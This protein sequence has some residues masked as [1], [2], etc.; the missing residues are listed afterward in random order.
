MVITNTT[1]L[2]TCRRPQCLESGRRDDIV[3]SGVEPD[4]PARP[5]TCHGLRYDRRVTDMIMTRR[6]ALAL[7]TGGLSSVADTRGSR[8]RFLLTSY[9]APPIGVAAILKRFLAQKPSSVNTDWFGTM[10][11]VGVLHWAPT[12][13]R[14]GRGLLKSVARSS[15]SDNGGCNHYRAIVRAR[16]GREASR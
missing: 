3:Q 12:W 9:E 6:H 4:P 7:I 8:R 11:L 15:S 2:I 13:R 16:R 10:E 1:A 5:A 14:G